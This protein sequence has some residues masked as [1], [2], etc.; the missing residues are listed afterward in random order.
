MIAKETYPKETPEV[1]IR[2]SPSRADRHRPQRETSGPRP[3]RFV[4][5]GRGERTLRFGSGTVAVSLVAA[6]LAG[7]TVDPRTRTDGSSVAAE[8][9]EG[10]TRST[11]VLSPFEGVGSVVAARRSDWCDAGQR[12]SPWDPGRLLCA[13]ERRVLI[14]PNS[15]DLPSAAAAMRRALDERGCAGA[16]LSDDQLARD[17]STAGGGVFS[18]S[19]CSGVTV[20]V[21]WYSDPAAAQKLNA[22]IPFSDSGFWLREGDFDASDLGRAATSKPFVWWVDAEYTYLKERA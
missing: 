12:Q 15:D 1:L 17:V 14:D 6:M 10:I 8:R 18:S 5:S 20:T 13:V 19:G 7:C 4:R 3:D 11:V 16:P 21:R 9:R 2:S 22:A